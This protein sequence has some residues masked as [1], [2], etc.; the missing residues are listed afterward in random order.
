MYRDKKRV[1]LSLFEGTRFLHLQKNKKTGTRGLTWLT[2]S[3]IYNIEQTKRGGVTHEYKQIY[4][5]IIAGS[6]GM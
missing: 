6:A 2:T 3:V 1:V 5:E 4:A